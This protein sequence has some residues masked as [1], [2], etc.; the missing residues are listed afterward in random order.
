M[1]VKNVQRTAFF[2]K[3]S[4]KYYKVDQN[5]KLVNF[6]IGT[7]VTDFIRNTVWG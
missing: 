1:I 6:E 7:V 3:V 2:N 5:M 4:C